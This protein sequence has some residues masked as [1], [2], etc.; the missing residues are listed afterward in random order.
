[1]KNMKKKILFTTAVLIS[2]CISLVGMNA[3]EAH[4]INV[5]AHIENALAVPVDGLDFGISF[6]QETA[7]KSFDLSLSDSFLQEAQCDPENLIA[8][9]SFEAP[10]VQDPALWDIFPSGTA[11]LIWQ[12]E[13]AD[14]NANSY[15]S[16]SRPEPAM[17]ELHRSVA[18]W[19]PKD[20]QQ[21]AELD[22]DWQGPSGSLDGEP[23]LVK[24]Y[25]DVPT[26]IGRSYHLSYWFSPRPGTGSS[27]N[28]LTA[29]ADNLVLRTDSSD[30]SP[31]ANTV[32]TNYTADFTATGLITR[33][34][35]V[36]GGTNDSLGVF[37]DD[38][39]LNSCGRVTAVRYVIR[40]KPKCADDNDPTVHPPVTEDAQGNF[41][42]PEGSSMMPLLCPYLS[43]H[44]TTG[45]G[46]EP[47]NDGTG[48]T[49]FHG[50]PG[51]WTL[52]IANA[53]A[54]NTTGELSAPLGDNDDT[55]NIDLK[56]PCFHGQ[57]A[58]DWPAFVQAENPSAD[59][60]AYEAD[61]ND[62]SSTFGCD[63]WLEVTEVLSTDLND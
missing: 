36:G 48:I 58:Q 47:E 39:A 62:E 43:K 32:W 52:A 46:T 14:I 40:Q 8:N 10:I 41:I 60:Q 44:E 33:I 35:F 38:V 16:V 6:P 29:M 11:S 20:G 18:G 12:A 59:P 49:A 63:L 28:E 55:W 22:S 9:G 31:N 4:V 30:G 51:P 21:H 23:A 34:A 42:C 7:D 24:I 53:M 37:L 27:Q 57:C 61:P 13:W 50:L 5:T 45:D 3:F 2:V 56:V 54:V 25:Q 26:V 1:M 19:L 15:Q 17:I